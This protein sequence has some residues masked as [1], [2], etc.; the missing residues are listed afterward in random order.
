METEREKERPGVFER[1]R[2]RKIERETGIGE[3]KENKHLGKQTFY[4]SIVFNKN[5]RIK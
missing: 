3:R 4:L 1:E 5:K 2:T